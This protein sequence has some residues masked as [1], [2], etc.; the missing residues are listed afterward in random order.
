ML[1][2]ENCAKAKDICAKCSA[3]NLTQLKA[4]RPAPASR[5]GKSKQKDEEECCHDAHEMSY[6]EI[7]EHFPEY[8]KELQET[9]R[10]AERTLR[11]VQRRLDKGEGHSHEEEEE[12]TH[13]CKHEEKG[14]E[15]KL[16]TK[17][18]DSCDDITDSSDCDVDDLSISDD[19]GSL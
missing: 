13:N 1:H 6:E 8:E 5:K 12:E 14:K 9:G 7:V 19:E 3:K 2:C 16:H 18:A 17:K 4:L 10:L 15:K 11:T